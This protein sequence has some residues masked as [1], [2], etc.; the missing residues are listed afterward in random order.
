MKKAFD[1][2]QS[3]ALPAFEFRKLQIIL[4][5]LSKI[6]KFVKWGIAFVL[7][8]KIVK[9]NGTNTLVLFSPGL[10]FLKM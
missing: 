7:W 2:I 1:I 10:R 5:I 8:A 9:N 4:E 6:I 3:E